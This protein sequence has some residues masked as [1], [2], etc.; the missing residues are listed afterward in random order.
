[1][2]K[3]FKPNLFP[4]NS[5]SNPPDW[6]VRLAFPDDWLYSLK[7]D[8]MRVELYRGVAY[9]RTKKVIKN[10][11]IQRM[12]KEFYDK[13]M[14]AGIIEGEFYAHGVGFSEL[15]HFFKKENVL[16]PKY[17]KTMEKKY[18]TAAWPYPGRSVEWATTWHADLKFHLFDWYSEGALGFS[19]TDRLEMLEIMVEKI[20]VDHIVEI[21]PH[22]GFTHIDE[23]YQAYDQAL[24]DGYEGLMLVKKDAPYKCGRYTENQALGFKAKEDMV[25]YKGTVIEVVEGTI[26][27]PN[28]AKT[29]DSMGSSRTSKKKGDRLPSGKADSL[30]VQLPSGLMCKVQI[31]GFDTNDRIA[32]LNSPKDL[33]YKNIVFLGMKPTKEGGAPRNGVY[34]KQKNL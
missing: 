30:R 9:S 27:D 7:L 14:H 16:D 28:V 17:K 19:K 15:S 2:F 29:I 24:I 3:D 6:E 1:M 4:N 32:L 21:I 23:F 22:H 25:A 5:K 13:T 12:A 26:A 20:D 18:G 34:T 33:L 10:V 11:E 31:N 8:G